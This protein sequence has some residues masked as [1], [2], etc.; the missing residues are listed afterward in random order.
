MQASVRS[1]YNH[2]LEYAI[3]LAN[4]REEELLVFFVLSPDYPGANLRH[5]WFLIEGLKDVLPALA[6]RGIPF[7]VFLGDPPAVASRIA[8]TTGTAS[9]G[10]GVVSLRIAPTAP[11]SRSSPTSLFPS[12]RRAPR[13]SG[14]RRR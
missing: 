9:S 5:Y 8:G 7:R 6:D 3:H 10:S 14:R 13:T 12:R 1:G 4:H 11:S 2:A